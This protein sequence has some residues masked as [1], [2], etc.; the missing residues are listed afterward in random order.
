MTSNV[1]NLTNATGRRKEVD[2]DDGPNVSN[3]TNVT[4]SVRYREVEVTVVA[5]SLGMSLSAAAAKAVEP[6]IIT[7]LASTSGVEATDVEG[8]APGAIEVTDAEV[9]GA[10][11]A[12]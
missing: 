7:G 9:V 5:S 12:C 10:F 8:G 4:A 11:A 3:V 1:S 2:F 6:A